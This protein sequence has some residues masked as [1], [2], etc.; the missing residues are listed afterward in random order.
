MMKKLVSF[1]AVALVAGG[2][3]ACNTPGERAVGGALIGGGS[4][5]LIGGA[6]GGDRGA[7][8]GAGIGAAS[9][10][11]IGANTRPDYGRPVY[12]S[13]PRPVY[14]QPAPVY[15]QPAPVYVQP[16]PYCPYGYARD[17]YGNVF[18]R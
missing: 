6:L 5:A 17:Y 7:L 8:L 14:V 4:G 16:R 3:A 13:R 18:C 10:A 9:G 11:V 15:V 2:L 12:Y 1:A